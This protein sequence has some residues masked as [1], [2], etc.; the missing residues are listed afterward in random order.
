MLGGYSRNV[1]WRARDDCQTATE[2]FPLPGSLT[3]EFAELS[4][5]FNDERC[6]HI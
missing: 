3:A 6:P 1:F 5:L 2:E 4:D